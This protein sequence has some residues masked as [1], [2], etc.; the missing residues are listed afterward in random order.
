[1]AYADRKK[2][3]TMLSKV[4]TNLVV[5]SVNDSLDFYE[6]ILGFGL[7]MAV[8]VGSRKIVTTCA[9]DTPLS[10]AII[11]RDDVELMLQSRRSLLQ[12]LPALKQQLGGAV[13]LYVRVSDVRELYESICHKVAVLKDLHTTFYGAE[14][15]YVLDRSGYVLTFAGSP[16]ESKA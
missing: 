8:P 6:R 5:S 16:K 12:E 13:T 1:M 4:T 2:E 3:N 7:V 9:G 11:K 15:F 10:F 14:E